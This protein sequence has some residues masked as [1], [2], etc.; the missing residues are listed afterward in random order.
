MRCL[1]LGKLHGDG[2]PRTGRADLSPALLRRLVNHVTS[3][4]VFP[5]KSSFGWVVSGPDWQ[6]PKPFVCPAPWCVGQSPFAR[7]TFTFRLS[8]PLSVSG[9]AVC[10]CERGSV[11]TPNRDD[12]GAHLSQD[13]CFAGI[14]KANTY[15]RLMQG[16]IGNLWCDTG[17]DSEQH[18][19]SP[20]SVLQ[21][22][23]KPLT[24]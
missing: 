19:P 12:S 20:R 17:G 4:V 18:Q 14:Q 1:A 2:N 22:R 7:H 13:P 10:E 6:K 5:P 16:P 11:H 24:L 9:S 15:W 3:R 8:L 21:W 23:T